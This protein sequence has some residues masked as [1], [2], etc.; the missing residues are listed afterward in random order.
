MKTF[1]FLFLVLLLLLTPLPGRCQKADLALRSRSKSY[2][3]V[4][5]AAVQAMA[6]G[7]RAKVVKMFSPR[8]TKSMGI[9]GI[10]KAL[11]SSTLPFF[12]GCKGPGRSLTVTPATDAF[13]NQGF[14]FYESA[15]FKNG[16]EKPFVIYVVREGKRLV[17]G[18]I[19]VN[20]TYE[21]MHRQ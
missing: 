15:A 8:F 12:A 9:K 2:Q 16:K 14:A 10:N 11:T 21:D 7:D 20:T 3:A 1:H 5:Q 19:L 17:V 6:R 13:G 18:N 4:A